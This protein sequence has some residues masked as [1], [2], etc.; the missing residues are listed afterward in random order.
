MNGARK[1]LS[2]TERNL[3]EKNKLLGVDNKTAENI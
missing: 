1:V 2:V 3:L